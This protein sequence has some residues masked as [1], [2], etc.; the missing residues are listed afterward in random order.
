[1]NVCR[2]CR[3]EIRWVKMES[4]KRNPLDP[5]PAAK[6]N[7]AL[8]G[9]GSRGVVLTGDELERARQEGEAL[10]LSHFATCPFA[11]EHRKGA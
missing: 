9:D 8:E 5:L 11:G 1:M 7:I 6:G 3:A 10:F 4:G 2:S